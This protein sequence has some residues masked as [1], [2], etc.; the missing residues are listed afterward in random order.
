MDLPEDDADLFGVMVKWLYSDRRYEIQRSAEDKTEDS[1]RITESIQLY[2][3]ADKYEIISLKTCIVKSLYDIIIGDGEAGPTLD[4]IAYAHQ[5]LPRGSGMRKMLTDYYAHRVNF[6]YHQP[7]TMW[8]QTHPDFAT[9]V[10]M[11]FLQYT[12]PGDL[13]G[14]FRR[15]TWGKMPRVYLR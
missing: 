4:T 12:P 2:V 6:G 3:L 8:L 15:K 7:I 10:L 14:P 9:D 5:N 11:S 1:A 13:N